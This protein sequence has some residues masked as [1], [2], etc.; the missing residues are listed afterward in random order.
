MKKTV[1][2]ICLVSLLTVKQEAQNQTLPAGTR[3]EYKQKNQV[4][5][6]EH[7]RQSADRAEKNLTL[8]AEQKAKW[9]TAALTRFRANQPLKQKM[10]GSTTPEE[11]K[12]LHSQ[13]KSNNAQF[14]LTVSS[15]LTSEQK[16]KYEQ[17]KTEKKNRKN[18]PGKMNGAR[19]GNTSP[20]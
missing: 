10:K 4:S 17:M 9:E 19:P 2:A 5:P 7:A 18:K 20:R 12:S 1:L 6:E 11:R 15:F 3:T 16:A 8:S 13:V 14:D